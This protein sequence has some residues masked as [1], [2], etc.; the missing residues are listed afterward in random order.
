MTSFSERYGF[1]S[2]RS[3]QID[4]VDE[5][6]RNRLWNY[7]FNEEFV[8]K[9]RGL[10]NSSWKSSKYG[11]VEDM[12]D[13]LG[14]RYENPDFGTGD[15]HNKRTLE[16][17]LI[18]CDWN[19]VY[20][21]IEKYLSLLSTEDELRVA[22]ELNE[23]LEEEKSGYRIIRETNNGESCFLVSPITDNWELDSIQEATNSGLRSVDVSMQKA[24]ALY[25]DRKT[26]DYANSIKES[27]S[28]VESMLTHTTGKEAT[29]S[30]N[31]KQLDKLNL[32]L[33]PAF[34]EALG[35]LYGFTSDSSGI[36]HGGY[37][38]PLHA[39]EQNARFMLVICSAFINY[40]KQAN[41]AGLNKD[42]ENA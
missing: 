2:E 31:L 7:F 26:P 38:E 19:R 30:S 17:F 11:I 36:R 41:Q 20:D 22:S 18:T 1:V 12:L 21:F 24:L 32:D 23:L 40:L 42:A 34:K 14:Y 5:P 13:L 15:L 37:S 10:L 8:E 25:S 35:K 6:L 28:A 3:I 33:H 4:S 39:T 16:E 29:L 9:Y 27:I